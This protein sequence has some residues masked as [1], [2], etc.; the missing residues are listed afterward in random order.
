[1]RWAGHVAHM[2]RAEVCTEFWWGS[3]EEKDHLEDPGINGRLILRRIFRNWD[4]G[5]WTESIWHR[6]GIGDGHL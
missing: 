3:L 4:V 2:G 6:T 1:M 5:A